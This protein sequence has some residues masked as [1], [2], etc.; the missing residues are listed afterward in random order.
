MRKITK[1]EEE[2][3]RQETK[4]WIWAFILEDFRK[5]KAEREERKRREEAG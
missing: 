5:Q 4:K 2:R 3:I 1:K